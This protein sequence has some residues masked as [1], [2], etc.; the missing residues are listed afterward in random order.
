MRRE[1]LGLILV[2]CAVTGYAFLPI[3]AARLRENGMAPFDVP[4]WRYLFTVPLFWLIALRGVRALIVRRLPRTG[5]ILLGFVLA[6][7]ALMSFIGLA[8]ISPGIYLVLYYTFPAMTAILSALMGERLGAVGWG[9]LAITLL[10]VT[11]TIADFDLTGRDQAWIGV[12]CALINAALASVYF[13]SM[14]RMLRGRNAT[15]TAGAITATG[16]L[17]F[18]GVLALVRGASSITL[19]APNGIDGWMALAGLVV[20]S[21]LIPLVTMNKGIQAAGASRAAIFGTI[22]PLLT[23]ILAQ[24]ILQVTMQP[25]QWVGGLLVVASVVLLQLRGG[26]GTP[27]AAAAAL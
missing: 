15:E 11:L 23:A 12:V 19:T 1:R 14:D 3:F 13:I 20:I 17:V 22:E 7:E 24:L 8:Y 18:L 16:A 26:D 6:I 10:G 27:E 2:L 4:F 21:T 9:A 5:L 25:I